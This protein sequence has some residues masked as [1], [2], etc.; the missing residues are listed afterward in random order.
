MFEHRLA[1]S[2]T[3]AMM[4]VGELGDTAASECSEDAVGKVL[5]TALSRRQLTERARCGEAQIVCGVSAR[6]TIRSFRGDAAMHCTK[7]SGTVLYWL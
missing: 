7:K 2:N 1:L 5:A 3:A 6:G 4:M